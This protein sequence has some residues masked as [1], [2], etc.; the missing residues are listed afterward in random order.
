MAGIAVGGLASGLDTNT[1]IT[2]L[3][4][5]ERQ[6]LTRLEASRM[7]VE[8]R[9]TALDDLAVRLR[10]LNTARADLT[11][12]ATFKD[13]QKIE[14]SDPLRVGAKAT[15]EG[16]AIPGTYAVAVTG[17]AEKQMWSMSQKQLGLLQFTTSI[18]VGTT[19]AN[20]KTYATTS[21]TTVAELAEKINADADR[22]VDARVSGGQL[23]L[24]SRVAGQA[25]YA[26]EGD[27]TRDTSSPTKSRDAKAAQFTM[28]YGGQAVAANAMTTSG[29][30]VR[31][32]GLEFDLRKVTAPGPA[33][34]VTVGALTKDYD[35]I[36][37]KVKAFV[38]SYN[39]AV[40]FARTKLAETK[41]KEPRTASDYAK[42]ALRGD[43]GLSAVM[44]NLRVE[45]GRRVELQP[46]GGD[47]LAEFGVS[48]LAPTSG[49]SDTDRLA[50]K[51]VIDEAKL[52]AA[53]ANDPAG[54][55]AVFKAVGK[56][57]EGVVEP[58]AKAATGILAG[59]AQQADSE[60]T[61]IRRREAE[62]EVRLDKRETRL[63]AYFTR[64]ETALQ[65]SQAQTSWLQGQIAGLGSSS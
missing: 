56:R 48:V 37:A 61:R 50:G 63:R 60:I 52:T 2:Q 65:A 9:K 34:T 55:E 64:L 22:V 7:R 27:F 24:E 25:F 28:T 36:K 8:G 16:E 45:I 10:G 46:A 43:V 39:A 11:A 58:F 54:A 41:V 3:M 23:V 12:V 13:V 33:V 30:T 20:A 1:M 47:T 62:F 35:W 21:G 17:L 31:Y 14:N 19:Q 4:A 42:G 5:I 51:L 57:I 59:R 15:V 38:E 32:G 40:D 18:K 6:P 49:K 53:I 26:G 29:N 44:S